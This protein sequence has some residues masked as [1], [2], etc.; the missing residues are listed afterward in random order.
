[1][2]FFVRVIVTVLFLSAVPAASSATASA[3]YC[4]EFTGEFTFYSV[5][6]PSFNPPS[7]SN[8]K[9]IGIDGGFTHDRAKAILADYRGDPNQKWLSRTCT[10]GGIDYLQFKNFKSKKCLDKSEGAPNGN[11]NIVHQYTCTQTDNQLWQRRSA[12]GS[13][14]NWQELWN[15]AGNRCL[16]IHNEQYVNGAQLVVWDCAPNNWDRESHTQQWNTF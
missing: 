11:G 1:M 15:F 6:D 7:S 13:K 9:V 3:P 16:D 14:G 10:T 5:L 12:G 2:K 8:R 4:P